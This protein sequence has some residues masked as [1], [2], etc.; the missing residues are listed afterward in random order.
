MRVPETHMFRHDT[1]RPRH[2]Q[3]P[4][5]TH[6]RRSKATVSCVGN[7]QSPRVYPIA[8]F[9]RTFPPFNWKLG[10]LSKPEISTC[11]G[12][13]CAYVCACAIG[14]VLVRMR[15]I[16]QSTHSHRVCTSA[17]VSM[18][19]RSIWV[20]SLGC[21]TMHVIQRVASSCHDG[22]TLI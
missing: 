17:C 21:S 2:T 1:V 18:S 5:S 3:S 19:G 6:T 16:V 9:A 11:R 12:S 7:G 22:L 4:V 13:G 15:M 14:C 20:R 10:I 8:T